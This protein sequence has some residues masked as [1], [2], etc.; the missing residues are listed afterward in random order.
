MNIYSKKTNFEKIYRETYNNTLKFV[1]IRCNNLDDVNDI[2]QDTYFELFKKL[3]KQ[4]IKTTDINNFIFGIANN[5]I[6]RHYSKKSKTSYF[7]NNNNDD[8]NEFNIVDDFNLEENFIT[9]ENVQFLWEYVKKKDLITAKIFNLYFALDM[10]ISDIAE[11]LDLD[12]SN[13]KNR[14]YRT[15]KELRKEVNNNEQQNL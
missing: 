3:K 13:V 14:I 9:K 4:K 5:I 11:N 15:L 8:K 12:I 1:I 2:I 7:I 6:K 10:K